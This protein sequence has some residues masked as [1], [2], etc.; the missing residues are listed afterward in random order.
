MATLNENTSKIQALIDNISKLPKNENATL[1]SVLSRTGKELNC[2]A[3]VF[4]ASCCTGWTELEK[5]RLPLAQ[6]FANQSF[7]NC[8]GLKLLDVGDSTRTDIYV[9][10]NS[11]YF[12]NGSFNTASALDVLVLR[13]NIVA[14]IQSKSVFLNTPL[15]N[16]LGLILVPM[17]IIEQYQAATNWVAV[18]STFKPIEMYTKDE[19]LTGELDEEAIENALKVIQGA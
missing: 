10:S 8:T 7:R 3:S 19:T 9:D 1:Y 4:G 13:P 14:T 2:D 15:V 6:S 18:G 11:L 17:D 16:G 5:A 12:T